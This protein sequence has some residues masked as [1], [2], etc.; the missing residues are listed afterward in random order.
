MTE[1]D[2]SSL[3]AQYPTII[4]QMPNTFTSHKFILELAR[5]NQ[6][7]YIDALYSYRNHPHRGI[8]APFM[9]VHGI[10]ARHLL[11]YPGLIEKIQDDVPS[12][13]IFNME[14]TCAEWRKVPHPVS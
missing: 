12:K 7:L 1:H 13:N 11:N 2:F 6:A 3:Y 4:G 10:L 8:P 9:M 5:Q 14:D